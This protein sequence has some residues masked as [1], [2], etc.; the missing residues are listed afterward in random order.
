MKQDKLNRTRDNLNTSDN[1]VNTAELKWKT[2]N[3]VQIVCEC[4]NNLQRHRTSNKTA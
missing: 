3:N 4:D 1:E 2:E